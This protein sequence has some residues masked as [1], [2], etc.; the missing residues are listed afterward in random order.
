MF[1]F[2]KTIE[3]LSPLEGKTLPLSECGDEAFAGEMLGKGLAILPS[4]GL[5]V[6][7]FDAKVEVLFD[8]AHALSLLSE[9][10]LE[11]LIHIGIDTV[12]LKG[13]HFKALVQQGA[14]VKAGDPLIEFDPQAIQQEGYSIIVPMVVCNSA[15]YVRIES[16]PGRNIRPLDKVILRLRKK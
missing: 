11:F 5:L 9:N 8:T 7:P 3:I 16:F 6:A 12:K 10:G 13:R 14:E 15:D 4:K 2:G 1:G